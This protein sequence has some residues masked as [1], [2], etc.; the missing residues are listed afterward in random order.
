M[1]WGYLYQGQFCNWQKKRRGT[2]AFDLKAA[3]FIVFLQNHD[4][5]A[6]TPGGRRL[7]RMTSPGRLRA[8]T[9]LMLLAPG[10]PALFQGQE[11]AASAPFHFFADHHEELARLVRSGR[12]RSLM[13]FRS[14][15]C[16]ESQERL[17]SPDDPATF[18]ACRLDFSERERHAEVY[19][20]HRD[21]LRLRREDTVIR[22]QDA[23]RIHGAVL[24]PEALAL[25]FFGKDGDDRLA[26][27]NL[28]RDL[29]LTAA[30]EPLLAP[31]EDARWTTLWSSEDPR[32]GGNGTPL[33]DGEDGWRLP[34]H[35]TVVLSPGPAPD[36]ARSQTATPS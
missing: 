33:P 30:P 16:P 11:F 7:D 14:A 12:A 5:I 10:T 4:Q 6:N 2:P 32:Y 25:R 18:R 13:Q 28:G 23:H 31:P 36:P 8:I 19:R 17:A 20:L 27:V 21:L 9:A 3:S 24:G 1:K 15:A 29:H 34:G 22:A 26:I 35:T